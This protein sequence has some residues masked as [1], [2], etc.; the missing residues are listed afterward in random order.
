MPSAALEMNGAAGIIKVRQ[1][2]ISERLESGRAGARR[3]PFSRATWNRTRPFSDSQTP[4]SGLTRSPSSA[5]GVKR[6][7]PAQV[8]WQSSLPL[9]SG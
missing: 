6:G 5:G 3:P 9:C 8:P 2:A 7:R 1:F 4:N